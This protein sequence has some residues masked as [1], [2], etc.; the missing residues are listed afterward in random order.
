MS[1]SLLS[2]I[3]MFSL[4]APLAPGVGSTSRQ[5]AWTRSG[6][7]FDRQPLILGTCGAAEQVYP[8]HD[9]WTHYSVD[10]RRSHR[11]YRSGVSGDAQVTAR[12]RKIRATVRTPNPSPVQPRILT[13]SVSFSSKIDISLSRVVQTRHSLTDK[14]RES[15]LLNRNQAAR[16]SA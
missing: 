2:A 13:V 9:S 15:R 5:K 6:S 4:L 3:S 11:N 14:S 8:R 1:T 7:S 12:A 16:S 10:V